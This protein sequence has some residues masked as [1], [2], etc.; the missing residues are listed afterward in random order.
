MKKMFDRFTWDERFWL[1]YWPSAILLVVQIGFATLNI[2]DPVKIT[3][4]YNAGLAGNAFGITWSLKGLYQAYI[5]RKGMKLI[6]HNFKVGVASIIEDHRGELEEMMVRSRK[7]IND[8]NEDPKIVLTELARETESFINQE[9]ER[10][11]SL[12]DESKIDKP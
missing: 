9:L 10:R 4:L 3:W 7:R 1:G 2:L 11:S 5:Y 6:H 8:G 12:A